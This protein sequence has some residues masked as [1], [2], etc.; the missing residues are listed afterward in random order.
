MGED[1]SHRT[2]RQVD[3]SPRY[4]LRTARQMRAPPDT[5]TRTKGTRLM[6]GRGEGRH[7]GRERLG[8][9]LVIVI[10]TMKKQVLEK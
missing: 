7:P 3:S 9:R 8:C 6:G 10:K 5:D 1:D 2:M 4:F